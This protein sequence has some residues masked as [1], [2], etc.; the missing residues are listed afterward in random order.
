MQANIGRGW[1]WLSGCVH[2][3]YADDR[4]MEVAWMVLQY[5]TGSGNV[6]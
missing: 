6:I 4:H 2:I 3:Y 1:V 5:F